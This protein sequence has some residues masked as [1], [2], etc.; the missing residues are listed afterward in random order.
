MAEV[1]G[2]LAGKVAVVTGAGSGIGLATAR[3]F[4]A[5]G[6]KVVCADIDEAAGRRP[7]PRSA[8]NSSPSTSPTEDE[9]RTLFADGGRRRYGGARHRVQQRRH[10]PAGR[11]LDPHH[12]HRRLAPG[13]GGEPDLGLP[14]LQVR[15]RA[16]ARGRRRLDHQHRVVRRGARLGDV[17]DLLHRQQ[18]RGARDEPR[19]RRAVRPRGDPGQRAVPRPG[20]HPAAARSFSPRT[21]SGRRGAWSTSRW[22]ASA[23]PRRSPPRWRSW[24]ATTRR[25][26]PRRRSWSTAASAAPTSRRSKR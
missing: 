23:S 25:S 21:P 26:S 24:P 17:A 7:R 9:V 15:H 16:H 4:A 6:A 19:A 22:A 8:A 14:V 20:E 2:R 12:R 18:G 1:S 5:E 10:L 11:R 13:A 3:R